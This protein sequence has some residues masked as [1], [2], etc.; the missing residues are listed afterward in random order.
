MHFKNETHI[1]FVVLTILFLSWTANAAAPGTPII[2][3]NPGTGN[4][5]VNYTWSPG[6]NTDSFNVSVNGTWNNGS[7]NTYSNTTVEP[8]GWANISVAGYNSASQQ[9]SKSD[10]MVKQVPNNRIVLTNVS[11]SYSLYE[12]QTLY[13]DA[14]YSDT[15]NDTGI[16]ASSAAK[17]TFDSSTGILSWTTTTGDGSTDG[18]VYDWSINVTDKYDPPVGKRIV[19]TVYTNIP[20][21][22]TGLSYT[23]DN[24][25]VNYTWLPGGGTDSFNVSVNGN[26]NNGSSNTYSNTTEVEPHGWV[27]ISIAG[28]NA[29][30]RQLSDFV[31]RSTQIPNNPIELRNVDGSYFLNEGDRLYIDAN[32]FDL[33]NDKGIFST[34][35]AKGT[36]DNSTGVLSWDTTSGD[37]GVYNWRISVT[38]GYGDE[39]STKEFKVIIPPRVRI[40]FIEPT[41][42]DNRE[43]W[44]DANFGHI[45]KYIGAEVSFNNKGE[46]LQFL[47]ITE[48]YNNTKT[49]LPE[50]MLQKGASFSYRK[51][52]EMN[53]SGVKDNLFKYTFEIESK[54]FNGNNYTFFY[55][56]TTTISLPVNQILKIKRANAGKSNE[57]ISYSLEA[58]ST[59][60]LTDVS[61]YDAL[62]PGKYFN[63]S[64]L[65][66]NGGVPLCYDEANNLTSC[67]R[68]Y[69]YPVNI[70]DLSK[71]GCDEGI[72]CVINMANFTG[73]IESSGEN[74]MDT[75]YSE[76]LIDAI[77]TGSSGGGNSGGSGG[78]G[79]GGGGLPPSEDFNNIERREV[80]EM[81]VLAKMA[82]AYTFKAADPVMAVSFESNVSD[83][84]VPVAVEVL[85]NRSKHIGVDAPGLVYKN[86]NIFVGVSGFSKKVGKGVVIFKVNNSWL[87]E[88][89]QNPKDIKL[90]KWQGDGWVEK[91]VEIV[92]SKPNQTYYA[93]LV[94]NFSSFAVTAVKKQA[95]TI[96]DP[97]PNSTES[98]NNSSRTTGEVGPPVT[99]N[100]IMGLITTIV[101]IGSIY[102]IK[103]KHKK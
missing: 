14:D 15:D 23:L 43:Q 21:K 27:N 42:I 29:I 35:A 30:S 51:E 65:K 57:P 45:G 39:A 10:Y 12:G 77:K 73:K 19:V 85:K 71:F 4:F 61:I 87:E 101:L 33:D 97:S 56:N 54:G 52:F 88:N 66:F 28:Y 58:N 26:W 102:Y 53:S 81:D 25:W 41:I 91:N 38:D 48:I 59:V 1:V 69:S 72:P 49:Q 79:G 46:E 67:S 16:F 3:S 86:F 63:L 20:N 94:G 34:N 22:P 6:E 7:S 9:L 83:N 64:K 62:Y 84:G 5:W 36:F 100:L 8:H 76:I 32:Y 24:F 40:K 17:G 82:V 95:I 55:K 74:I 90:Y 44:V 78:G 96:P 18:R 11:G 75:E 31:S 99:L 92:E 68:N 93:S 50:F 47:N 13:I 60:D 89:G 2:N 37:G 80:R 98:E 70:N 103:I